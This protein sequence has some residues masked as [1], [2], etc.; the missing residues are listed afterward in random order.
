MGRRFFSL[1]HPLSSSK[2]CLSNK[3]NNSLKKYLFYLS[4]RARR[5]GERSSILWFMPQWPQGP[6]RVWRPGRNQEPG[7]PF[8][9]FTWLTG[10]QA[11]RPSAGSWSGTGLP[12]SHSEHD[13]LHHTPPHH[14][15]PTSRFSIFSQKQNVSFSLSRTISFC[16]TSGWPVLSLL[17]F[18]NKLI[19]YLIFHDHLKNLES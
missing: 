13:S 3:I 9:S 17:G 4:Q 7:A 11:L 14:T 19:L 8:R 12:D 2:V 1:S 10:P 16:V 15:N 18:P 5:V 6:G